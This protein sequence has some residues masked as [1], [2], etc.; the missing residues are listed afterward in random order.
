MKR[1]EGKKGVGRPRE[2]DR[3][4]GERKHRSIFCTEYE[5]SMLRE[6]LQYYRRKDLDKDLHYIISNRKHDEKSA[7]FSGKM[8]Y[9]KSLGPEW[10]KIKKMGKK[11]AEE[12]E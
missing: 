10:S 6:V 11:V 5:Q 2:Y 12:E 7:K 8:S 1:E 4:D 3:V 9:I